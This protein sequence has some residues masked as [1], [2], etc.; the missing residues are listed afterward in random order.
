MAIIGTVEGRLWKDAETFNF[1]D[2]KVGIRISLVSNNTRSYAVENPE[3]TWVNATLWRGGEKL[4]GQFVKGRQ[5]MLVGEIE[6]LRAPDGKNYNLQI[7]VDQFVLG[8]VPGAPKEP[9]YKG[10]SYSNT[11]ENFNGGVEDTQ[12]YNPFT[13]GDPDD[14]SF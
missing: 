6:Q 5:V 10:P 1:G 12:N 9:A 4:A 11:S 3:P 7:N 8:V 14:D 2:G 13:V